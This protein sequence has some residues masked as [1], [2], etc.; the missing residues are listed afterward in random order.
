M[1][2]K[3]RR[4]ET[5]LQ[6]PYTGPYEVLER[7]ENNVKIDVNGKAVL[8]HLDRLKP[9]FLAQ[10]VAEPQPPQTV[11]FSASRASREDKRSTRPPIRFRDYIPH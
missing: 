3:G 8:V 1:S 6:Q 4:R 9:A 7:R 2:L 11:P 10:D 5:T